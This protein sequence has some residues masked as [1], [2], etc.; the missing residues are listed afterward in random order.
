MVMGDGYA[1]EMKMDEQTKK[2]DYIAGFKGR[3]VAKIYQEY[4]ISQSM[5]YAWRDQFYDAYG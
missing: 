3:S 1:K 4:Q 5:Y 2:S